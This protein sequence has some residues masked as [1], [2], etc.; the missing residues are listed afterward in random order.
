MLVHW[1]TG[2]WITNIFLGSLGSAVAALFAAMWETVFA[3]LGFGSS[4]GS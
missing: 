3:L 2:D 1:L 4:N